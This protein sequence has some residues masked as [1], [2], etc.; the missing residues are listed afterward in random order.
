MSAW[1]VIAHTEVG[2]GGQAEIEFASISGTF[3]D[4]LLLT[5]T[6]QEKSGVNIGRIQFNSST[7]NFTLRYLEG[8]GSSATSASNNNAFAALVQGSDS[9]ANTY[10]NNSIYIS[11]YAGSTNKSY[12]VDTVTENNATSAF[13]HLQAGLWSNTAA[14]TNIKIAPDSGDFEQYSSA[15]LYGITK[16]SSGGV[17]VS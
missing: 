6:R 14:I 10:T 1:T 16:G 8:N 11:N 2:S 7:S 3:T 5:S 13:Q 9:T 12:S 17:T 4:L 15:T